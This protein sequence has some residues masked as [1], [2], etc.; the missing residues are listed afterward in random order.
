M[1]AHLHVRSWDSACWIMHPSV[2]PQLIQMTNG[3]TN[4]P[5]LVWLSP[6]GDGSGGG[7][8]SMKLPK[9]FLNGLPIYFTEKV[10]QLG[11]TGDV[12]LVDWSQYVIGNRLDYQI[13][14][15]K[16]YL[17]R[18]NQLAWRVVARCDG[19]PWLNNYITDVQGWTSS[20]FVALNS[21][22]S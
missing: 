21:A 12:S 9:A 3:A 22:T 1:M 8:A 6:T 7:P 13:D 11:T 16:D 4:S 19:K 18:T 2:I 10:P 14:V 15:S 17:F 5:Y 20:P